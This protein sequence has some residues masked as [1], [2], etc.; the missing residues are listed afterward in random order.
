METEK[1]KRQKYEI[2]KHV[3]V[4]STICLKYKERQEILK[5]E[6]TNS[7]IPE[8]KLYMVSQT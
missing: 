3:A 6:K 1:R 5:M 8:L 4:V 2:L 7:K